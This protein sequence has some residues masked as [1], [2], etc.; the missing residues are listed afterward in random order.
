[1]S[2]NNYNK[3]FTNSNETVT[4]QETTRVE[5]MENQQLCSGDEKSPTSETTNVTEAESTS[6]IT[7]P[8]SATNDTSDD[9][10]LIGTVINCKMLRV[11]SAGTT[12]ANI[13][14]VI[15]ADSEVI[16][17]VNHSTDDFY[18]VTTSSGADG[19]CMK[20]FIKAE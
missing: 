15:P 16:I 5:T 8:I 12:S 19:Y 6:E 4:H 17:D 18:K 13:V 20:E 9:D 11:R 3:N 7:K 2:D 14:C 1:M 10:M